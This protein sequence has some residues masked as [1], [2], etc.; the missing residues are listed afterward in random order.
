MVGN[1]LSQEWGGTVRIGSIGINI[2][3]HVVVHDVLLV[4]PTNDT[5]ARVG[6]VGVR[7]DGI[8]KTENGLQLRFVS[9]RNVDY[10]LETDSTGINLEYIITRYRKEKKPDAKPKPFT[11]NVKRIVLTNLN[12]RQDLNPRT[13]AE[14]DS[15]NAL[16]KSMPHTGPGVDIAHMRYSNLRG[17]I[18]GFCIDETGRITCKIHE[19]S[20][21]EKSGFNLLHLE[22]DIDVGNGGIVA[23]NMVL[24]TDSTHLEADMQLRYT[25]WKSMKYFCD[26]VYLYANFKPNTRASMATAAYWAPV[27]WGT[28]TAAEIIGTVSGPVADLHAQNMV[29]RIGRGTELIFDGRITG[30]PHIETTTINANLERLSTNYADLNAVHYPVRM[31]PIVLPAILKELGQMDMVASFDGLISDFKAS[32]SINSAVG[33]ILAEATLKRNERGVYRYQGEVSSPSISLRRIASNEWV[34]E[35]GFSINFNGQDFD[36]RKMVANVD[37]RLHNTIFRGTPL[38]EVALDVEM[39][40]GVAQANVDIAHRLLTLDLN[41]TADLTTRKPFARLDAEIHRADLKALHLWNQEK[42]SLFL[43]STL[44][45]AEAQIDLDEES[46]LES[47]DADI[48]L[49]NTHVARNDEEIRLNPIEISS[50]RRGLRKMMRLNS[51]IADAQLSGYYRF[52]DFPLIIR[53]FFDQ[54]VPVYFN[55]FQGRKEGVDYAAIADADFSLDMTWRDREAK[56]PLLLP[57]VL[58]APNT[59]INCNFNYAQNL[60]LV[61]TSDSLRLGGMRINDLNMQGNDL[62]GRFMIDCHADHFAFGST[63]LMERMRMQLVATPNRASCGLDWNNSIDST[64]GNVSLIMESSPDSNIIRIAQNRIFIHGTRWNVLA[65][66]GILFGRKLLQ[67]DNLEVRSQEQSLA[68]DAQINGRE[69]DS[70]AARFINFDLAQ[71][72]FLLEGTGCS[73][74]GRMNG[75]FNLIHLS[76]TPLLNADLGIRGLTFNDEVLGDAILL[77]NWNPENSRLELDLESMLA[78]EAGAYQPLIAQGYIEMGQK[79][80]TL[81]FDLSLNRFNLQALAPFVRSFSSVLEGQLDGSLSVNGT[82]SKPLIEGG[83]RI[84]DGLLHVDFINIPF[85]VDDSVTI[86]PDKVILD[87]FAIRDPKGNPV[88]LNGVLSH[89]GFKDIRFDVDFK[90][91]NLWIMNTGAQ[92]SDFYGTIFV[93]ANGQMKGSERGIDILVDAVTKSGSRIYFPISN[94]RQVKKQGFIRF[95]DDDP[96][97]DTEVHGNQLTDSRKSSGMDYHITLNLN[98]TPDANVGLPM[99][100]SLIKADALVAGQ[101]DLQLSLSSTSDLSILGIYEVSSGNMNLS[102]MGLVT[103]AFTLEEGSTIEFRGGIPDAVFDLEA[104]ITQ[105]VNLATL[106]GVSSSSDLSSQSIAVRDI[107]KVSGTLESPQI[108][109]DIRLPNADPS[110]EEEVFSYID[111]TDERDMLNQSISLLVSGSFFNNT[112]SNSTSL[113]NSGYSVLANA[114]GSVVS[115]MVSFVDVSFDYQAASELTRQQFDVDINKDFGRFYLESTLGI[116][117]GDNINEQTQ[118][119]TGDVLV[120]YKIRPNVHFFVFN[121][122]NTNDYTRADQPYK[123]GMGIKLTKD[124]DNVRELFTRKKKKARN[125]Q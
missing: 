49:L 93:G 117:E 34:S 113:E 103:K 110:V 39:N 41:A 86:K 65:D 20:C 81:N 31:K 87:N 36:L 100:F 4:S 72:G 13:Q 105:R 112:A 17:R 6:R 76:S 77:A 10:H 8:P 106:T 84:H 79:D 45:E 52:A 102:A 116:S 55:P 62:S 21:H 107:I 2:V 115:G 89:E 109:F 53:R 14:L 54:Y 32:A 82:A 28:T 22:G 73:V 104:G 118:Q 9:V 66:N 44:L 50:H 70:L 80:P 99:D 58:I 71:I 74:E 7:F 68:V 47:L 97:W 18:S 75:N 29:V 24:T 11:L 40:R 5:I 60:K 95:V 123:Q 26:S 37:G 57:S 121:R 124:F 1:R 51:E 91:D 78:I 16:G 15:L 25:S 92:N 56:M 90:T 88:Y 114:L 38:S 108:G 67:M 85:S 48:S 35:T 43:V 63:T 122:S 98:V 23:N 111:R 59:R 125:Q 3:D 64:S 46:P 101:G 42:D 96:Y 30:L 120:G 12:Y 61:A 119:I 69:E 33:H 94:K 19:L 83:L 27:L